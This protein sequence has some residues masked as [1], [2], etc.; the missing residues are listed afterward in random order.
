M[1][2]EDMRPSAIDAAMRACVPTDE[3]L[4]LMAIGLQEPIETMLDNPAAST[5]VCT[6]GCQDMHF[7][8]K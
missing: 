7:E 5:D 1:E 6:R 2:A 3:L 4:K 8:A